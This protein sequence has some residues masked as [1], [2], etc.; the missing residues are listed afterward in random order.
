[1]PDVTNWTSSEIISFCNIIGLKYE[2]NGYGQVESTSLEVGSAIDLN[3]KSA[4]NL[5]IEKKRV[6]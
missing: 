2:L 6:A 5:V 1:M 3:D 4:I